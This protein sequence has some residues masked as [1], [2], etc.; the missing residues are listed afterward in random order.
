M[1]PEPALQ[2]K[3]RVAASISWL[4]LLI[5]EGPMEGSSVSAPGAGQ[6]KLGDGDRGGLENNTVLRAPHPRLE[7]V[8]HTHFW[9]ERPMEPPRESQTHTGA[10]ISEPSSSQ[11]QV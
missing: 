6:R 8:P 1:G 9:M 2:L 7:L 11:V 3:M 4:E 10:K 5:V